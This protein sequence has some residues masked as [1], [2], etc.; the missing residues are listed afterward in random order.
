[1]AGVGIMLPKAHSKP[2]DNQ[3]RD[4]RNMNSS[5]FDYK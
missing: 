5:P 4:I 1:M 2:F 3:Y